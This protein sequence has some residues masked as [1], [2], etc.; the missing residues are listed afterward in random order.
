[1]TYTGVVVYLQMVRGRTKSG[2]TGWKRWFWLLAIVLLPFPARA[3]TPPASPLTGNIL[4]TGNVSTL[5]R[6]LPSANERLTLD[7]A[8]PK[9]QIFDLR[10]EN[11][12]EGSYNEN[13]PGVLGRNINEHKFEVQ[14]TYMYPLTSM[15]SVSGAL[16]H[17]TNF[18]FH[19][20]YQWAIATLAAKIPLS[21]KL[22]LTP[23][24]SLEKRLRGG[25]VFWDTSAT[26][27]YSFA[28]DWTFEANLHR[29]ENF[30]EFD[31][32]PTEKE[33]IEAGFI[34]LLTSNQTLALSFFRHIQFGAPNDQFSFLKLKY[35]YSF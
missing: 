27:D 10:V 7:Y 13:P 28:Q 14:G 3:D 8:L 21:E 26:L 12:T 34:H 30:G 35:G 1:M 22:S 16:L 31:P 18:T 24:A 29:Y 33:E 5:D 20:N 6:P 19:D 17:H 2:R 23:N 15:F 9:G 32:H 11:Y 25:R 4:L